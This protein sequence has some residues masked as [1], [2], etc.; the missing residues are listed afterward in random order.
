MGGLEVVGLKVWLQA[1]LHAPN[2][3]CNLAI[4]VPAAEAAS[5]P[6]PR[7][8]AY[9]QLHVKGALPGCSAAGVVLWEICTGATPIRGQL[10]DV[11]WAACT[12]RCTKL[13][14][15]G[16]SF[17]GHPGWA[18]LLAALRARGLQAGRC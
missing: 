10:R 5:P 4:N 9:M 6:S 7:S 16:H 17:P 18:C 14:T 15:A 13:H 2:S 1:K 3:P 12:A 8:C 11:R